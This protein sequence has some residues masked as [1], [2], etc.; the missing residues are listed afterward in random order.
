MHQ[1]AQFYFSWKMT[2]YPPNR[3]LTLNVHYQWP[4]FASNSRV[5]MS[6]YKLAAFFVVF[7]EN[8]P[9]TPNSLILPF[10]A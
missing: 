9:V 4:I 7:R 1:I 5:S 3:L 10:N 2:Q 6:Q 8:M